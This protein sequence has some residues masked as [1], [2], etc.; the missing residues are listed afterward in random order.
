MTN[1]SL[2]LQITLF[3]HGAQSVK[4]LSFCKHT[5]VGGGFRGIIIFAVCEDGAI[6]EG[7][8]ITGWMVQLHLGEINAKREKKGKNIKRT[9]LVLF[10]ATAIKS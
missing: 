4:Y 5:D 2:L 8:I 1:T 9:Y 6:E 3:K 10:T 7:Q